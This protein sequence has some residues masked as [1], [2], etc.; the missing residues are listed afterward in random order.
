M[1]LS[2]LYIVGITVEAVT[3]ALSA[4]RQRMDLFGVI[5][6]ACMTALGGGTIRDIMLGNYPLTWVE[7][8]KYLI[9]VCGAAL[10]TVSISW[11]MHYFRVLFLVLD[12]IGLS[13]FAVLGA[14]AAL[15]QG[16]GLVIAVVAAVVTGVFG[17]VLRDIFSDRMPLVFSS[18]FYAMVAVLAAGLYVGLLELE[19]PEPV[20]IIV[21]LIVAFVI[22][23]FAIYYKMGLPVFEYRGAEQPIDPRVRLSYRLLRRGWRSARR[24]S[25]LDTARYHLLNRQARRKRR[26]VDEPTDAED[27]TWSMEVD[28]PG[29]L[30]PGPEDEIQDWPTGKPEEGGAAP[31]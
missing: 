10:L 29:R 8:P 13:V 27:T 18:E 7:H 30:A 26:A 1:L 23:L 19:V 12:A 22:R 21:T 24:R 31:A 14:Q 17:G 20:A 6:I 16:H 11:L 25:G 28:M 2:V 5:A 4:G 3:A 9:I 15:A